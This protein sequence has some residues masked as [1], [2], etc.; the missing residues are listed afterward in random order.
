MSYYFYE[1]LCDLWDPWKGV[2]DHQGPPDLLR[3]AALHWSR[4]NKNKLVH[5]SQL[6]SSQPLKW[7]VCD[8]LTQRLISIVRNRLK[9]VPWHFIEKN[10]CWFLWWKRRVECL[11]RLITSATRADDQKTWRH[12]IM[13]KQGLQTFHSVSH[14]T[15][16]VDFWNRCG[17]F[18]LES[19]FLSS[20]DTDCFWYYFVRHP[21]LVAVKKKRP[22]WAETSTRQLAFVG[23]IPT[24]DQAEVSAMEKP[25][26]A[27]SF[28]LTR[29][30]D[31][32]GPSEPC[33]SLLNV[34]K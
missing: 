16:T 11:T 7:G 5:L 12:S 23:C 6:Q 14:W 26:D 9:G 28:D 24:Q 2:G 29:K 1:H 25:T 27:A 10:V 19:Y 20:S 18:P 4:M 22:E 13:F 31:I 3:T 21:G 34:F 32:F 15:N 8:L 17:G 33:K 30:P